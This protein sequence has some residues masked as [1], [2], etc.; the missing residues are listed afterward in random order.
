MTFVPDPKY[1]NIGE[2]VELTKDFYVEDFRGTF[3]K[4]TKFKVL[5]IYK[6]LILWN[7]PFIRISYTLQEVESTEY[8]PRTVYYVPNKYLARIANVDDVH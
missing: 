2:V 4:G 8:V 7:W 1:F 6:E 3:V 5:S